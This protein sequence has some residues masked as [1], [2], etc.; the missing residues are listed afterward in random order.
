MKRLLCVLLFVASLPLFG[1]EDPVAR[2]RALATAGQ[3]DEAMRLLETRLAASPADLD[4]RTLYGTILSWNG[5]YARARTELERVLA[6]DPDNADARLAL[7]NVERWSRTQAPAREASVGVEYE[8]L[9]A[10]DWLQVHAAAK[11]GT[12]VVRGSHADRGELDDQQ[13]EVELYPRITPRSYAYVTGAVSSDGALYP[14]WRVGGEYFFGFGNGFEASAGYR[15]LAFDDAVDLFTA[16]LGKY[17]GNWLFQ[18]RTYANDGDFAWQGVARR[19]L[20]EEGAYVGLRA[21]T[22]RDEIRS[23]L[24]VIALD[25]REI[26]AE[27]LWIVQSRWTL[28]GRAG[29]ATRNGDNRA[30]AAFTLGLRY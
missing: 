8:E 18:A 22:A 26:A 3:R 14:D 7:T 19:Y 20:G 12:F 13:V 4:A 10:G 24:D 1:Q 25:E 9:A 28:G 29:V 27:A 6:A 15:H 5:E 23:G 17:A 2:A 30:L 11:F 21:G 16:S